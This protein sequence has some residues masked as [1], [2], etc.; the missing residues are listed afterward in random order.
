[1]LLRFILWKQSYWHEEAILLFA[2][3]QIFH[4]KLFFTGIST[5]ILLT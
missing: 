5:I 2:F 3:L 1:M 4:Y